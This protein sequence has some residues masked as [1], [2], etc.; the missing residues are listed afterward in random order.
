M[1]VTNE[2]KL[3]QIAGYSNKSHWR[4]RQFV[5]DINLQISNYRLLAREKRGTFVAQ[6]CSRESNVLEV[7]LMSA[8]GISNER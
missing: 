6:F 5:K 4:V 1:E 8:L 2:W 7:K 3:K